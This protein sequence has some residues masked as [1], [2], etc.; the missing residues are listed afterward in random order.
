MESQTLSPMWYSRPVGADLGVA[1]C[2]GEGYGKAQPKMSS[3][4]VEILYTWHWVHSIFQRGPVVVRGLS[5]QSLATHAV[6]AENHRK[7][8]RPC[9]LTLAKMVHEELVVRR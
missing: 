1:V 5:R 9:I 8:K 7:A 4:N 2:K 6:C 3:N